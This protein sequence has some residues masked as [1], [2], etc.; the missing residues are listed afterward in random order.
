M[1]KILF[2][3]TAN[4]AFYIK[5]NRRKQPKHCRNMQTVYVTVYAENFLEIKIIS[6]KNKKGIKQCQSHYL[7]W[8][9]VFRSRQYCKRQY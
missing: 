2:E 9:I 3:I 7:F 8:E 5:K 1:K 6:Q 4:N